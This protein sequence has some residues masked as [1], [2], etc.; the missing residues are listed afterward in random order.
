M[1]GHRGSRDVDRC[2]NRDC[3]RD[4]GC[5]PSHSRA[6]CRAG[7]NVEPVAA[8]NSAAP[9]HS[10]V[11]AALHRFAAPGNKSNG[12]HC[13]KHIHLQRRLR[14]GYTHRIRSNRDLHSNQ[15]ESEPVKQA[16]RVVDTWRPPGPR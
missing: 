2:D 15:Q 1:K 4:S 14:A 6:V 11:A 16:A 5:H 3:H 7:N 9:G 8:R 10:S 13:H 12:S